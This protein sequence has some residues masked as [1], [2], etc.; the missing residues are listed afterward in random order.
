MFCL[1]DSSAR[2]LAPLSDLDYFDTQRVELGREITPLAVWNLITEESRPGLQ[3]AFNLRDRVSGL[4]GVKA[5]NGFSGKTVESASIGE[6][7]DFFLVEYMDE[8]TL[9]L[10]E[11]DRHLDVMTCIATDLR[12]VSITVSVQVHNGFGRAYMVPVGLAHRW[13]V[14]GMLNRLKRKVHK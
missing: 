5:I 7:L 10:T 6:R 11:R 12:W 14:R 13:I 8:T 9:V 1:P 2:S 3:L 4:F